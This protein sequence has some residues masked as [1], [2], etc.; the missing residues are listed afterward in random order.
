MNAIKC[1]S[2]TDNVYLFAPY[3]LP[4][5]LLP[6]TAGVPDSETGKIVLPPALNLG[7]DRIERNGVYL[8][9][10]GRELVFYVGAGASSDSCVQLFGKPYHQ[11]VAGKVPLKHTLISRFCF[12]GQKVRWQNELATS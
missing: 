3:L 7:S 12:Q 6:E 11:L 5:H 8:L 2:V 9:D 4:I 10:D 1:G